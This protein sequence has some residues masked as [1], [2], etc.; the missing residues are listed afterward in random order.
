MRNRIHLSTANLGA[1]PIS[2]GNFKNRKSFSDQQEMK[3]RKISLRN[4]PSASSLFSLRELEEKMIKLLLS[5]SSKQDERQSKEEK[6]DST[7]SHRF[8][9]D[10]SSMD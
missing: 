2:S 1:K 5:S 10:L 3:K 6:E 7:H 9:T 4:S 8:P